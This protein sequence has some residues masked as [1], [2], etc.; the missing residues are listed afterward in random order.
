[1][2]GDC[3]TRPR[4]LSL[5]FIMARQADW[6]RMLLLFAAPIALRLAL[7]ADHPMPTPSGSDDFSYVLLGDT[8]AHFRLA[9]PPHPFSRFFE[10]VF[11]LQ[12]P[13]YSSK[14]P[15][16]QGLALALGLLLVGHP[17]AGVLISEGLLCALCYWMLRGWTTRGWATVGGLLAV[18][19]FG[20]LSP[21][22]NNY[23]GGAVAGT[24]GCVVLGALPRLKDTGRLRYA[25]A[26]GA[27]LG[28]ESLARPFESTLLA[29]S[30]LLFLIPRRKLAAELAVAALT[31]APAAALILLHNHAVTGSWTTLP[32]MLSRYQYGVPATF[33]FQT[34][35]IPHR[36][37][38][39]EQQKIYEI[40]A[41]VHR[42]GTDTTR[43][44]L[45]RLV[46]RL[47]TYRFFF[48]PALYVALIAFFPA[49]RERRYQ[50]VVL[51]VVIFMA[52]TN[53]Y[54]Y[55]YPHYIAA[56]TSLFVL[57]SVTGLT[58]LDRWR[59]WAARL[60]LLGCAA[61]F[62]FWYGVHL[63]GDERLM[64]LNQYPPN[65]IN[66]GD[67]EGRAAIHKQLRDVPGKHLVF[68]RRGPQLGFSTW[69]QNSADIDHAQ[70]VWARDLGPVENKQ[71]RHY[72]SDRTVW[73]LEPDVRPP[74]LNLYPAGGM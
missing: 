38:T 37:L 35:P 20:P 54:P 47:D 7:L 6:A 48:Y 8:L 63:Y 26:L 28:L 25:S 74:K 55:F 29:L 39:L 11:V 49:L 50:W 31:A 45:S 73:L 43:R 44:Y 70:V 1:M 72:H 58:V 12:D 9:N 46:T 17:W 66:W 19:Q 67:P 15:L 23:Y 68:V 69:V 2:T 57:M 52:G 42:T 27:G 51:T 24:A 53:F 30:V 4:R 60:V 34:N 62:F 41:S 65:Y 16:G 10:T 13:T 18:C 32:Y 71:L 22:M 61:Q 33:T 64:M 59:P 5:G 21:W 3:Q 14:F 40:Q 36:V 56:L